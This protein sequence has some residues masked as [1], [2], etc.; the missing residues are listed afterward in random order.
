MA[1]SGHGVDPGGEVRAAGPS[2]PSGVV[3]P[4]DQC[5]PARVGIDDLLEIRI[6]V[7]FDG[8][9]HRRT[10][11]V[12][13]EGDHVAGSG[14]RHDPV[15]D[16]PGLGT[17]L[18][19]H[20][21]AAGQPRHTD[22]RQDGR[23]YPPGQLADTECGQEQESR[24]RYPGI[25]FRIS[26][27]TG[28]VDQV[29]E[30]ERDEPQR[31]QVTSGHPSGRDDV[32]PVI[33]RPARQA[34]QRR[35][36]Q[37]DPE[38][39]ARGRRSGPV[40]HRV[41]QDLRLYPRRPRR[42]RVQHLKQEGRHPG[43]EHHGRR[44]HRQQRGQRRATNG[45]PSARSD[46][47][48]HRN[49]GDQ[50]KRPIVRV[51]QRRGGHGQHRQSAPCRAFQRPHQREPEQQHQQDHQRVHPGLAAVP[52]RVWRARE[53]QQGRRPHPPGR[54]AVA[55]AEHR[56]HPPDP[57]PGDPGDRQGDQR[58]DARQRPDRDVP[59]PE[60]PDPHVQEQV[61]QGRR[62]VVA[63]RV[64]QLTDRSARDLHRERFV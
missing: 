58:Q 14:Q 62:T 41:Q 3:D 35:S 48:E 5:R 7:A 28:G 45:R 39:R 23:A 61:V 29:G 9:E 37:N 36:E 27:T 10:Q 22:N 33:L 54:G 42:A 32:Q 18:P 59:G 57:P 31:D 44:Q 55:A 56:R 20:V 43:C 63:Q 4:V 46:R 24:Q 19:R 47:E 60:Q 16:L 1:R 53:Q 30:G 11:L 15:R 34:E 38:Q 40:E 13:A 25:A 21:P 51:D 2:H 49:G 26:T 8:P 17:F 50:Q 64:E 52:D 6:A 12:G